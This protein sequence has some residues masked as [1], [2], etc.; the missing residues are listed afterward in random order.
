MEELITKDLSYNEVYGPVPVS[1]NLKVLSLYEEHTF[2][3]PLK[4]VRDS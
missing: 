4:D 2:S 1:L 3:V